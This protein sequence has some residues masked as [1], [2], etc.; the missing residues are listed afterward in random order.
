[1]SF[2]GQPLFLSV[3]SG[4]IAVLVY[5]LAVHRKTLPDPADSSAAAADDTRPTHQWVNAHLGVFVV[6][7]VL[8]YGSFA[9]ADNA[10]TCRFVDAAPD[11]QTGSSPPF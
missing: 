8:V 4:C 5:Y 11:I 10:G 3:V 6:V 2:Y 7:S 1:M 9:I